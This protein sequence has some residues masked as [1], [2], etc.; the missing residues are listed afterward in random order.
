MA[1]IVLQL[2]EEGLESLITN[3][4][5]RAISKFPKQTSPEKPLS[6]EEA[7]E[8]LRLRPQTVYQKISS[9]P[10]SKV[11]KILLFKRE[12]LL[13]YIESNKRKTNKE[14][15]NQSENYLGNCKVSR[16]AI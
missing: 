7:A 13:K 11:G 5:D 16:N 1:M 9:I 8:F 15:L 3:A 12:D 6:L 4:V 10:H 2:T 14:I